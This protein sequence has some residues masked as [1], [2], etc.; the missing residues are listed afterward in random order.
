MTESVSNISKEPFDSQDYNSGIGK[1]IIPSGLSRTDY[2]SYCQLNKT[3]SIFIEGEQVKNNVPFC[4]SLINL[5]EFPENS[6]DF[7][8]VVFWQADLQNGGLIITNILSSKYS[9][10][11]EKDSFS[12]S[13]VD[14]YSS[15]S[16]KGNKINNTIDIL[17]SSESEVSPK[18]NITVI[19]ANK[20][21]KPEIAISCSGDIN[22]KS[23]NEIKIEAFNSVN[24]KCGNSFL[25]LEEDEIVFN[26]KKVKI[27]EGD[28]NSILGSVFE[29]FM[30]E[31][32]DELSN[33]TVLT[34]TGQ[35]PIFNKDK[36]SKM[37]KNIET[38]ISENLL[39]N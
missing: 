10:S 21:T 38:F 33:I 4:L 23:S 31:F 6:K 7:G 30:N 37:K 14:S 19:S 15:V 13:K 34:S 11:F 39:L 25:T 16:V 22:V 5:I 12:L 27:N 1:I 2:I 17:I 18:L 28:N 3:L 29:K 36:V 20:N 9:D 32:I 8:S 24:L 35:M 26:S